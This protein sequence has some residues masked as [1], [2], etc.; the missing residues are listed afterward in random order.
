ML[1]RHKSIQPIEAIFF[2]AK[3]HFLGLCRDKYKD[4]PKF[5]EYLKIPSIDKIDIKSHFGKI[6]AINDFDILYHIEENIWNNNV[7]LQLNIKDI[8]FSE[9]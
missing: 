9:S 8:R 5:L 6:A 4:N 1:Y 2:N 3:E 7:T